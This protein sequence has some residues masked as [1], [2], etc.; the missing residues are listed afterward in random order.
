VPVA[1][2]T[3]TTC[4]FVDGQVPY[5]DIDCT[6]A[7]GT[8]PADTERFMTH[9]YIMGFQFNPSGTYTLAASV[10]RGDGTDLDEALQPTDF[11]TTDAGTASVGYSGP[12]MLINGAGSQ[13]AYIK[14]GIVITIVENTVGYPGLN[15]AQTFQYAGV[16]TDFTFFNTAQPIIRDLT[17]TTYNQRYYDLLTTRYQIYGLSSFFIA[18]LDP[19]ITVI[20]YEL[21]VGPSSSVLFQTDNV[22]YMT[23]VLISADQWSKISG[24]VCSVSSSIERM[25]VQ[26]YLSTVPTLQNNQQTIFQTSADLDFNYFAAGS[27]L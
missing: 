4:G 19:N 15:R 8:L 2:D 25:I 27:Y 14:I 11:I 6:G 20:N 23:Q 10:L 22:N 16:Y 1:A 5:Y 9:L 26:K 13:L 21:T 24:Q 18:N 7:A 12:D 3:D 17:L